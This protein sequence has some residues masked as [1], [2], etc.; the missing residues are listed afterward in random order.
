MDEKQTY[1][2]KIWKL[3]QQTT[4]KK[5]KKVEC[6]VSKRDKESKL[7]LLDNELDKSID[8]EEDEY[9]RDVSKHFKSYSILGQDMFCE[10]EKRIAYMY[11]NGIYEG[12]SKVKEVNLAKPRETPKPVLVSIDLINEEEGDLIALLKEYKD[13]LA[14][15]YD[16][17]KGVTLE[18]V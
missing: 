14:W 11:D 18:V 9:L 13:C 3:S 12:P 7:S 10:K 2:L 15:P 8:E 17:M 1:N 4:W 16:D 6:T 5:P